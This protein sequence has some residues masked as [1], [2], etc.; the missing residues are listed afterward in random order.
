MNLQSNNLQAGAAAYPSPF[1]AI[2]SN[3][4]TV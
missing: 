3:E 1:R 2:G 4:W